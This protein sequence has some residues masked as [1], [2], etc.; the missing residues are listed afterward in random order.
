MKIKVPIDGGIKII[1][2]IFTNCANE[3]FFATLKNKFECSYPIVEMQNVSGDPTNNELD[4]LNGRF[5]ARGG[6]FGI[7]VCRKVDDENSVYDR[8]KTYLPNHC[9]IFLNDEDIFQL[10]EYS[11]ENAAEEI[12]DFMDNKLRRLLF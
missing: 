10:L 1:D 12:N 3:G 9:I 4:Q 11:R 6:E 8:C 7:Q 2:A 5:S